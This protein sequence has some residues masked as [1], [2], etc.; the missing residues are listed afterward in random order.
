MKLSVIMILV[1]SIFFSAQAVAERSVD[2]TIK[3]VRTY[4]NGLVV[5]VAE[6]VNAN[7]S[8]PDHLQLYLGAVENYNASVSLFMAAW[9]QGKKIRAYYDGCGST[10]TASGSGNVYVSGWMVLQ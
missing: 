6:P 10:K 9:A 7:C 2:L 4:T 5:Q 1:S 8:Y 3:N